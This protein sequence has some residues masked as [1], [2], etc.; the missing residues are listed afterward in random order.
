M[1]GYQTLIQI[2]LNYLRQLDIRSTLP[3]P[4]HQGLMGLDDI[5]TTREFYLQVADTND[6]DA[7]ARYE[8]LLEASGEKT[9]V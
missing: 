5:T 6:R 2:L 4:V 7:T 1:V 9:C 8:H 3:I